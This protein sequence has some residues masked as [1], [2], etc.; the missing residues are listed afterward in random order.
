MIFFVF[1]SDKNECAAVPNPCKV[2][3]HQVCVNTNGSYRCDC[4]DKYR[5]NS[6]STACEGEQFGDNNYDDDDDDGDNEKTAIIKIIMQFSRQ[7]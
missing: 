7:E 1:L 4:A 2:S 3:G 5:K 6:A